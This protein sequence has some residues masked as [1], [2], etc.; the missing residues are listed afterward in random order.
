MTSAAKFSQ[1]MTI[2][3]AGKIAA[4]FVGLGIM[5]ILT[6]SLG[7]EGFGE[8][9][10]A[11]TFLQLF[12]VIVDFGLTLTL[13]VMI[14]EVGADQN[15]I[16]SNILTLRLF[17][18]LILFALAPLAVLP[19]AW[20]ANV[21]LGVAV[22][23]AAF[24]FMSGAT[25]LVGVFQRHACLWRSALA[26]ML[27]RFIL[28]ALVALLA[29]LN[30]GVVWMI[31][32]M[33]VANL[34]WLVSMIYFARPFIAI[35]PRFDWPLWKKV[36]SRSW[37]IAVSI[38]FNLLYL[39][40]DI[41]FLA[42]FRDAAEVGLYGAAYKII[43]VLTALPVMFM[44]LLLPILVSSW[45]ANDRPEFKKRLARTFDIFMISAI[46]IVI[47]TQAVAEPL[48]LLF[49]GPGFAATG[50]VLRWLIIS[51]IGV[52][53]GALYG[54]TV[55]ALN[56]QK[57]MIWGY[58]AVAVLSIIGYLWLIPLYGMYGAAYV[59]IFSELLIAL[60][61]FLM[62][63]RVSQALPSLLVTLKA[64]VSAAIMFGVIQ[65]LPSLPVLLTVLIGALVYLGLMIFLR[66]LNPKELKLL[67][68]DQS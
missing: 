16:T 13:L 47:G 66:G 6:R 61:T 54:H 5:A 57:Q 56:K 52:F 20:S 4:V 42:Y 25:M 28:I 18:G 11:V 50:S 58:V 8:Y 67:I 37:P 44:G 26:E 68:A 9:T 2:Q 30:L 27:N 45:S 33:I 55:V 23:A 17:S 31:G 10:T 43:D 14:S 19:F 51:I 49:A 15:K 38:I 53:L 12:G 36:I 39:K 59:T 24:L 62:V 41:L 1:N 40:G 32:A 29:Y 3:I 35:R 7:P 34:A 65:S 48:A 46:P 60:I 63:W 64:L 22:G 21:K